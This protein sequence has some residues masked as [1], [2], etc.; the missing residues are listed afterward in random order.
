[1]SW[2]PEQWLLPSLVVPVGA[3]AGSDAQQKG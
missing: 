2:S 3:T 1:M